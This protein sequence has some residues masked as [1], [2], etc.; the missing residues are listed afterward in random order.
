MAD[1]I[2]I[3]SPSKGVCYLYGTARVGDVY[4]VITTTFPDNALIFVDDEY[5]AMYG[6]VETVKCGFVQDLEDAHCEVVDYDTEVS[7]YNKIN[8]KS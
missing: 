1:I 4:G 5:E 3:T 6:F 2:K 7:E 8:H